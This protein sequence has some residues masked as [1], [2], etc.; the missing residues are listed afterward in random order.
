ML[1]A[2]VDQKGVT[3][4]YEDHRDSPAILVVLAAGAILI[5]AFVVANCS[6]FWESQ[7]VRRCVYGKL[8]V[9]ARHRVPTAWDAFF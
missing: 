7:K 2:D 3:S 5:P 9:N 6:R 8:G 4:L 1:I